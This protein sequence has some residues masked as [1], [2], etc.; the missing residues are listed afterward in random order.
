MRV[1]TNNYKRSIILTRQAGHKISDKELSDWKS[2][3]IESDQISCKSRSKTCPLRLLTCQIKQKMGFGHGQSCPQLFCHH[4][5]SFI[6]SPGLNLE[7]GETFF[8]TNKDT[9]W[10]PV[11]CSQTEV[12]HALLLYL[13]H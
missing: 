6:N 8:E 13:K 7:I 1:L 2:N 12:G 9:S 10:R 5:Q 3:Q 11:G 4:F